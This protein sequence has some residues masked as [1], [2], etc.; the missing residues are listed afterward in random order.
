MKKSLLSLAIAA[1]LSISVGCGGGGGSG[2]GDGGSP[3]TPAVSASKLEGTAAAGIIKD[4]IVTAYELGSNGEPLQVD[5][6]DKVV[7]TTRTD[8]NGQYILSFN[9]TYDGGI[10]KVIITADD[11][12]D[13]V[14]DAFGD[15]SCGASK[16]FGS[17]VKLPEGFAI[18]AIVNPQGSDTISVQITPLTHM[19]A[20]RA[21]FGG[22][23]NAESVANAISEVSSLAGVNIM[24]T[25]VPDITDVDSL[26]GASENAKQLALFNAGLASVLFAN[27]VAANFNDKL[28]ELSSSFA[29]G[30]FDS[31]DAIKI[32][33]I[34]TAVGNA[35]TAAAANSTIQGE[36]ESAVA[37]VA[38]VVEVIENDT[39][40]GSYN[41]EP[42]DSANQS[43]INQAKSLLTDARTFIEKI[44]EDFETP[45]DALSVDAETAGEI[46]SDDT[47]IMGALLGEV[48]RQVLEDI[49]AKTTLSDELGNPSEYTT[50]LV[51]GVNGET[52]TGAV[53]SVFSTTGGISLTLNGQLTGAEFEGD[54]RSVTISDLKL[55]TNLTESDLTVV[56]GV[57][58]GFTANDIDLELTGL[59]GND[60]T[61]L[62][63][64]NVALS[65]ATTGVD[66]DLTD[67]LSSDSEVS[68]S[69]I[70]SST[71]TS[72]VT[73]YVG[74]EE[75]DEN[76]AA[77]TGA[78]F[79]GEF[80]VNA[81]GATFAGDVE[82]KLVD[83]DDS[84]DTENPLSVQKVAVDGEFSSE[85]GSFSAGASLTLSNATTFDTFGLL[86]HESSYNSN[87]AFTYE[88]TLGDA[89]KV[90]S[91]YSLL[92]AEQGSEV[93]NGWISLNSIEGYRLHVY[94]AD[95]GYVSQSI[96]LSSA[97]EDT[98][99]ARVKEE[100]GTEVDS[101]NIWYCEIHTS[102]FAYLHVNASL[103][104]F[105]SADNF[106]T[107]TVMLSTT[108]NVP[109]L[110]EASVVTT[111]NRTALSGGDVNVTVAYD[112]Q[113]FTLSTESADVDSEE[114]EAILTLTNPD[115]V[116][117]LMNLK[118]AGGD[119]SVL[120]GTVTVSDTVVGTISETDSGIVL[121]RYTD[122]TFESLF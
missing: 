68:S 67:D 2:G 46:L 78:S 26:A 74:K 86:N 13:M 117:M 121:V 10:V 18:N 61:S 31:D 112:G 12:T 52:I 90:L 8:V 115:N 11:N 16:G 116:K 33:E 64:V 107:G 118:K 14:C 103:V 82:I 114:P 37:T 93:A 56:D 63:L 73:L 72:G 60:D 42:T 34:S 83:L 29:D 119:V 102:G 39:T 62:E 96:E 49:D 17:D 65:I 47:A 104:G 77:V 71:D 19:A 43:K 92:S 1:T 81:N 38:A 110:P 7:G 22:E 75:Q 101:L 69:P 24:D 91:V 45:L 21:V 66:I 106:V 80:I 88:P 89:A 41:P 30:D 48:V 28:D 111:F 54:V 6:E 94:F 76:I 36:L 25:A 9:D 108:A 59:I 84:V 95:G 55:A 105:E 50:T 53:T 122:G 27:D 23:V 44:E 120:G 5:G 40:D 79:D 15:N 113:S 70:D 3:S 35:V 20:A 4:G 109:E 58:E 99:A 51:N 87:M 85:K 97:F 32:T 57:L 100:T 98:V